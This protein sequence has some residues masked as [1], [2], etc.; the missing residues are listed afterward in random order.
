MVNCAWKHT[1]VTRLSSCVKEEMGVLHNSP[2]SLFNSETKTNVLSVSICGV[3]V[4]FTPVFFFD[5]EK[6]F[7]M[8]LEPLLMQKVGAKVRQRTARD[9]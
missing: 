8:D 1:S 4:N 7:R 2:Y 5:S 9:V 3:I 6:R